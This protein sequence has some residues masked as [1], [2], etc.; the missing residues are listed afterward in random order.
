MKNLVSLFTTGLVVVFA[1]GGCSLGSE[2][3][4]GENA[5]PSPGGW[6]GENPAYGEKYEDYGENPF[7]DVT[8]APVST[9][10]V[11][12]DG[13]SYTNMRR[14]LNFGQNPPKEAVRIEEFINYFTFNYPDGDH[15]VSTDAEVVRCPWNEAH[16]LIRIGLKGKDIPFAELPAT[17]YVFLIDVS[18]SMDSPD[19]LGILKT[20]FLRL[21]DVL[22]DRDRVAI[23]TYSGNVRV[24][25]PSTHGDERVKIRKA[26]EGLSASGSTAG[27][28]AIKMAYEMAVENYIPGG[29]NRII[30]GTD[31]DFNV[32]ISSDDE[33]T[34]LIERERDK[35]I[36]ITVL[37]VGAGNLNDSMMEK[38]AGKGNGTYEY[39]DNVDQIEKVFVNERSKFYAVAKDCKI[40]VEFNPAR[41]SKYRLI[42][43]ENRV[44]NEEDFEDDTK[45]AGDIGVGQTV[46]ALY[47]I[48][49]VIPDDVLTPRSS[50]CASFEVRYK[51]PGEDE[52]IL[53]SADVDYMDYGQDFGNNSSETK[54]AA[55][56]AAF[57]MLLK[58]SEYAGTADKEMVLNLCRGGL[59]FD[60]H[61]YRADFIELVEKANF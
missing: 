2:D 49:P 15:N 37:G 51:K 42:G 10:S 57:G 50:P 12:C 1:A 17:N 11:D 21:T 29:N 39:I 40:Q 25:L 43:Y 7:F 60:P 6:Y 48:V 9:F 46:T 22:G 44:M 24:A 47:E 19:K 20:G 4:L 8:D 27:G 41:V 52:S 3:Y 35:G 61:G 45:D 54:F 56:V 28:A 18:G 30:L 53:L 36:Y 23:V 34:E 58:E 16:E 13:A 32:G 59:A 14:W 55:G 33:L 26:I 5:Y 38:V 31:G